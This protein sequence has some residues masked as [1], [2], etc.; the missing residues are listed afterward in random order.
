MNALQDVLTYLEHL[1]LAIRYALTLEPR[2]FEV[3]LQNPSANSV[4]IGIVFLAGA[5]TLLGQSVVLFVNRVR[6]GRF[7][8]S[9][10]LNGLIYVISYLV[11]GAIIALV[12]G[13]LFNDPPPF[14]AV[15]RMVGLSTA[16]LIFGF[17]ILIPWM[18]PFIGRVLNIWGFL[19]LVNVVEFGF[20]VGLIKALVCVGLGWLSIMLLNN[21]VGRPV[22][23][24]RNRLWIQVAGASLD[25]STNDLLLEF[26]QVHDAPELLRGINQ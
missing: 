11:W 26:S 9:L 3:V 23:A 10:T 16:P 12:G 2:L 15:I 6:R 24:L 8:L 21:F 5:S 1:F 25:A 19:I 20:Q 18:G 22:L 14:P 7:F 13:L 4:V 17:F